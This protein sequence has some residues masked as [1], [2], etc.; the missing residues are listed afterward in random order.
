MLTVGIVDDGIGFVPT[1]TKL[2]QVVSAHF[3]CMVDSGLF[4]LGNC[5]S[6]QLMTVG[7]HALAKL[8]ELG[9]DAV[10]FSSVALSSR[11]LRPLTF[12]HPDATIFGCDA[13]V[14]HASTYTASRVLVVGD[15]F[16]VGSITLSG[17][18][19]VPMPDF[20]TIAESGDER[21][22]V[23]YI[24]ECCEPFY[25][26]FDCIALANSSMNV[27]K[28]CFSRVFPNVH[29]FDSLE[30]VARKI[31]KKYRKFSKDDSFVNVIDANGADISEKYSI[32]LD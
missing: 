27:Y 8:T 3:I 21:D 30:G 12:A 22:V 24:S 23:R 9:C 5:N 25:G 29:I 1:L 10:V 15:R 16:A 7:S 11:C 20:P 14:L 2:R 32:F 19:P 4:P 26:Q 31:R 6:A 18:I 17:I 13:P 28:H